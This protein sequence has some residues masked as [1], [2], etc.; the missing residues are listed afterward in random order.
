MLIEANAIEIAVAIKTQGW[1]CNL[2]GFDQLEIQ[3]NR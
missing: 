1:R 3:L 2:F